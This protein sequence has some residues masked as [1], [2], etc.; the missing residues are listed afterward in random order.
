VNFEKEIIALKNRNIKTIH[1]R[2]IWL[3]DL[4][5]TK[6]IEIQKMR[7][8]LIFRKFNKR[9]FT[10]IPIT[11]QKPYG[12]ITEKLFYEVKQK[13]AEIFRFLLQGDECP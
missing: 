6:G 1:E 11:S 7:P 8:C 12:R 3:V 4:D 10:V 9:Q 13:T 5:P 2:E